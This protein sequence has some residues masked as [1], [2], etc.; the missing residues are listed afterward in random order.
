MKH[1]FFYK[2]CVNCTRSYRLNSFSCDELLLQKDSV[3]VVISIISTVKLFCL[4]TFNG[5]KVEST[6]G[7][8][9]FVTLTGSFC[10]LRLF[11]HQSVQNLGSTIL[12]ISSN[13]S[14][15]ITD[16]VCGVY[17]PVL[18][19]PGNGFYVQAKTLVY[20]SL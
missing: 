3:F 9:L 16:N 6:V 17:Y 14:V 7:Y 12:S 19:S 13:D 5:R 2:W 10:C 4:I 18:V 1:H 20:C 8:L 11:R 15:M